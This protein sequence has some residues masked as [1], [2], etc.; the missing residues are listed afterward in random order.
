MGALTIE[1][2]EVPAQRSARFCDGV[3]GLE[4]DLLVL[5]DL[6]S[7]STSTLS[8]Q[9]PLPSMLMAIPFFSRMLVNASLVN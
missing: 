7:R 3:V 8:R 2:V 6:Q 1:K 9:E 5:T 4:V